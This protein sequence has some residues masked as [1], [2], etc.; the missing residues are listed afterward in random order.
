MQGYAALTIIHAR[1]SWHKQ[2]GWSVKSPQ[3]SRSSLKAEDIIPNEEV[4]SKC[5]TALHYAIFGGH[6]QGSEAFRECGT[7]ATLPSSS[8]QVTGG[9]DED[10]ECG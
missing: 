4:M 2:T 6:L 9:T 3:G 10:P 1:S 5:A 7:Q 8:E